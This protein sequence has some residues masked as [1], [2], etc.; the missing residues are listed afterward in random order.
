MG[1]VLNRPSEAIV[2]EAVPPL[3]ELVADDDAVWAGGPVQPDGVIVVAAFSEPE[4][5]AELV[6]EDVGFMPAEADPDEIAVETRR[7][8]VFAGYAGWGAGQLEEELG[9]E[10]WFVEPA[11][12][13]DV[14]NPGGDLW[15]EVL[16]RKGGAYA[17]LA[18][19]P[20]NP[21]LN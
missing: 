17:V 15:S 6:F 8:R 10:A 9:E 2:A 14:F 3:A 16:A 1:L 5:A 4:A 7:A 13:E 11:V 19:M 12:E 20:P 18:K 21:S